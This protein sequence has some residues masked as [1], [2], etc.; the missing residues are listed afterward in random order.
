MRSIFCRKS[1]GN[2]TVEAA[3]VF[4]IVILTIITILLISLKMAD[5]TRKNADNN[6][7]YSAEIIDPSFPAEM[8]LRLKWLG[9]ELLTDD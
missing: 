5:I 7:K 2:A 9:K 4:P 3:I 1:R 8:V 6:K